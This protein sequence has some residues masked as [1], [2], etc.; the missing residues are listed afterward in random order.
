MILSEFRSFVKNSLQQIYSSNELDQL[1]KS[2]LMSRLKMDSTTYLLSSETKVSDEI[3]VQLRDDVDRLFR[4]EPLQYVLGCTSFYGLEIQCSP[5][6][7]IPRPETEELVDWVLSEVQLPSCA[8][9]DLGTGTG[10]VP[11]A[12]KAERP[13]WVVSAIDVSQEALA[14]A[15]SNATKA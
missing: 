10:C 8:L 5:A 11:L 6:A 2:L 13:S 15:R 9:I 3:L 12:I 1:A 14:L 4:H 7:L